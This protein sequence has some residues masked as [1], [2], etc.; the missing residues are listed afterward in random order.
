MFFQVDPKLQ[1]IMIPLRDAVRSSSTPVITYSMVTLCSAIFLDAVWFGARAESVIKRFTLIPLDISRT[2]L[3]GRFPLV[4]SAT[5]MKSVFFAWD[6]DAS[7]QKHVPSMYLRRQC[8]RQDRAQSIP[9]ILFVNR[10]RSRI[11]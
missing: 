1:E 2:I 10:R 3:R 6:G 5:F 9:C 4:V 7:P 11:C 8:G